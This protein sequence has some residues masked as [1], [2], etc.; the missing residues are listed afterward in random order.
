MRQGYQ[1]VRRRLEDCFSQQIFKYPVAT[2]Y[3]YQNQRFLAVLFF[4][5]QWTWVY[6]QQRGVV[7]PEVGH[8]RAGWPDDGW[9]DVRALTDPDGHG[10]RRALLHPPAQQGGQ[11]GGRHGWRRVFK[12]GLGLRAAVMLGRWARAWGC[13]ERWKSMITKV[14]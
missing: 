5:L 9:V 4:A 12:R 8:L 11:A 7:V 14:R 13:F 6:L 2:T 10:P 3:K 1:F